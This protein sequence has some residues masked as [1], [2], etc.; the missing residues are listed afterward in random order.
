MAWVQTIPEEEASGDL[1][2]VYEKARKR[3]G[4]LPN[5]ARLQSLRP[6]TLTC[7]FELYCQLMDDPSGLPKKERVMIATVVS[8]TN[9][10]YY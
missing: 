3:A 5:I 2:I 1:A 4:V 10:C 8:K 9:G 7:S 6:R